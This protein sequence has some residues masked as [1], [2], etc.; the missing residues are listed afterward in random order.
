LIFPFSAFCYLVLVK[1]VEDKGCKLGGVA[2]GEE[3]LVDLL[4]A[5][6]VQLTT[7]AVFNKTLIPAKRTGKINMIGRVGKKK[8]ERLSL[9][10]DEPKD[11]TQTSLPCEDKLI[12]VLEC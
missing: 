8:K 3:L 9:C 11:K 6:C 12:A 10:K 2:E 5:S 7:G 1:D 4:K